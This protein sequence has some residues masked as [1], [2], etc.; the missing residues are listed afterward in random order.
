[1]QRQRID[2]EQ[3]P[4]AA[5]LELNVPGAAWPSGADAQSDYRLD[6]TTWLRALVD[7]NYDARKRVFDAVLATMLLVVLAPFLLAIALAVTHSTGGPALF[8]QRRHGR[9]RTVFEVL[10]FRTM[11]GSDDDPGTAQWRVDDSRITKIGRFLRVRGLDELP[12]LVNVIKGEMSLVG[13]RPHPVAMDEHYDA[14]LPGYSRRFDVLPGISGL[15]QVR[16]YRGPVVD[17]SDMEKRLSSDI[18]YTRRRSLLF[19]FII[20]IRTGATLLA[21][22]RGR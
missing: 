20:L 12:Q 11:A 17:I 2:I 19:D 7:G 14:A 9:N 5:V 6:R 8:R 15:A 4:D 16:G 21:A 10:K 1:M 3:A 18:E 22:S 13:P